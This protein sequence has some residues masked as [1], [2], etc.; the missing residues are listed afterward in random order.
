ME[1]PSVDRGLSGNGSS[2]SRWIAIGA[3]LVVL[4]GAAAY[5]LSHSRGGG[6]IEQAAKD[7]GN[8]KGAPQFELKDSDGKAHRLSE[9]KGNVVV[10]HFWASW[11]PPCLEEI[12]GWLKFAEQFQGPNEKVKVKFVAISLDE[13]WNDAHKILPQSALPANVMSLIDLSK[14]TPDK[15]GTYQF[16]ETY[17][18][19]PD[20][21]IVTKWVGAQAW[22]NP[23]LRSI[24]ERVAKGS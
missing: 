3:A 16:P 8:F 2:K 15:Y 7:R 1:K 24:I 13:S 17:L 14:E 18:I 11:C 9:L 4:G 6:A 20:L 10:L 12:A 5:W 21:T 23:A 22:E 19:G